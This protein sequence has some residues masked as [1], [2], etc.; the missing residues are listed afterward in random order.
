MIAGQILQ[1]PFV[2][3]SV[4]DR[5]EDLLERFFVEAA[6][7]DP[8]VRLS[9]Q[10]CLWKI[11]TEALGKGSQSKIPVQAICN[12]ISEQD[13]CSGKISAQELYIRALFAQ[14]SLRGLLARPLDKISP[15]GLLARSLDEI[16]LPALWKVLSARFM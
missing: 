15:R 4:E 3:I 13:L 7:Q 8:Y 16:S 1:V 5:V 2:K 14:I 6:V 10:G 11:S 9:V 12:E